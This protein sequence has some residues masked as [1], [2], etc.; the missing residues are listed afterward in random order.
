VYLIYI[1]FEMNSSS[2]FRSST[3]ISGAFAEDSI[4]VSGAWDSDEK[5][6]ADG[7]SSA[8]RPLF[9]SKGA[10]QMFGPASLMG[11]GVDIVSHLL[12]SIGR[13]G[14]DA[15]NAGFCATDDFPDDIPVHT[16]EHDSKLLCECHPFALPD[17]TV[18][19]MKGCANGEHCTGRN[20]NLDGH[21]ESGGGVVL[22][23]LLT[24]SELS[25]FE[26]TGENPEGPRL[27]VLCARWYIATAY[28]WCQEQR[29]EQILQNTVINWFVNPRDS[30]SGYRAEYMIPLGSYPGWRCMVGPV[31]LNNLHKLRLVRRGR[32][33][34][35]DQSKLL[36]HSDGHAAN[37]DSADVQ[38]FR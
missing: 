6:I 35:V 12:S 7:L 14:K 13:Q 15:A 22:R 33:W 8:L 21:D 10:P 25:T 20:P 29:N 16:A 31:V 28:F 30:P 34:W 19:Q 2:N 36:W 4:G 27:C 23:G 3:E 26:R 32:V 1:C 9:P 11:G 18:A 17:G 5:A 38:A 37:G 24:P